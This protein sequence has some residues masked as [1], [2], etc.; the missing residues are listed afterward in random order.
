[1]RFAL[2]FTLTLLF[3]T[4]GTAQIPAQLDTILTRTLDS[5]RTLLGIKSMSAAM[6]FPN[7]TWASAS[8]NSQNV[9]N[10]LAKPNMSYLIG[11]TTK[12]I[13]SACILQ[14]ADEGKLSLNDSIYKYV[15]SIPNINPNITIRQ[16]LQHKTGVFDVLLNPAWNQASTSNQTKIWDA[17]ELLRTFNLPPNAAPGGPWDYS[18]PNYFLLGMIIKKVS[19]KPFHEELR[20]RFFDPLGLSSFAIPAF[21]PIAGPV[22]HVWLDLNGDGVTEDAHNFYMNWKALNSAAGA[23]GGYFATATDVAKW[24]RTYMRGDLLSPDMLAQAKTTVSAPGSPGGAYGLGLMRHTIQGLQCFGH[25]GDLVYTCNAWYFPMKDM[26]I[27]VQGNDQKYDSWK[28]FPA[29]NALIKACK[30]WDATTA[31]SALT[32]PTFQVEAFPNPFTN[33]IQLR[34]ETSQTTDQLRVELLDILGRSLKEIRVEHM[35]VG[36]TYYKFE[37]MDQIPNGIYFIRLVGNGAEM[38]TVAVSKQ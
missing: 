27:A 25:G 11:S 21:E 31:T 13:V 19:G 23:A 4:R 26:S 32:A 5:M 38:K 6:Q 18:N 34:V 20:A 7:Y 3:S 30:A 9:P 17:E 8:G 2:L 1:M 35:P 10:I 29:I 15:D 28:L 12:T 33:E 22:A 24:M 37:D 16:L 36:E 14:I